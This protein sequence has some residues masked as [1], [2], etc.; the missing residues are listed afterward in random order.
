MV[1]DM[2]ANK[3]TKTSATA[4][5]SKDIADFCDLD[6]VLSDFEDVNSDATRGKTTT[7]DGTPAIILNERDGKDRYTLYVATEGKPYLLRVI[8]KSA[9]EPGDLTF[10]DYNKPVPAEAPKGKVIDLDEEW[11]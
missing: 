3:W 11:S 5:D 9:K 1:V 8:S 4:K 2:L 10:T 6:T 7:V